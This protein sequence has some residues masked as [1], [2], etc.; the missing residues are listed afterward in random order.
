MCTP[1]QYLSLLVASGKMCGRGGG[2]VY[3]GYVIGAM[4]VIQLG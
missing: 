2:V 1:T 4:Q 3:G